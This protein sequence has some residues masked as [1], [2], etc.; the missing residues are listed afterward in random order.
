MKNP[1]R[2]LG[3]ATAGFDSIIPII[4]LVAWI[5]RKFLEGWKQYKENPPES[6]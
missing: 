2:F 5:L 6:E 3:F 1:V 4:S